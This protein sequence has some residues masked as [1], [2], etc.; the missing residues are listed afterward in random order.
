MLTKAIKS[1]HSPRA[2]QPLC[3][4]LAARQETPQFCR[5]GCLG[6]SGGEA[7][8]NHGGLYRAERFTGGSPLTH[9]TDI[10]ALLVFSLHTWG[11]GG[12]D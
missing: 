2:A 7:A 1:I 3:S 12:S 5:P 9:T 10:C 4:T 8:M 6:E 11:N